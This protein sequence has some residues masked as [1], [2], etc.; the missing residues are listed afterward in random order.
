[1]RQPPARVSI[2]FDISDVAIEEVDMRALIAAGVVLVWAG[3]LSAAQMNLDDCRFPDVPSVPDGATASEEAMG[4]AGAEVRAF[5]AEIQGALECL[6][7]V[8]KSLG[9]AITDEQQAELVGR[10]NGAVDQMNAVANA[11]NA[12]VRAYRER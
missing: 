6:T 11:Y 5:V 9:N 4:R 1:L 12:A 3:A 10:Y 2:S 7:E 8:E